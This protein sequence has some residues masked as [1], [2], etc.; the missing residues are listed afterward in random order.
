MRPEREVLETMRQESY[1]RERWWSTNYASSPELFWFSGVVQRLV[2]SCLSSC[3]SRAQQNGQRNRTDFGLLYPPSHARAAAAP[4]G[5]SFFWW[6]VLSRQWLVREEKA[7]PMRVS[8]E[9]LALALSCRIRSAVGAAAPPGRKMGPVFRQADRFKG[10]E[11]P[12]EM[13]KGAGA[14]PLFRN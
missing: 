4:S 10:R 8:S 9:G 7:G 12:L 5:R 3:C 13:K 2:Y 11:K 1:R 14:S 6:T